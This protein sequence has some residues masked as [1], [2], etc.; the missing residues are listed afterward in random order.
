MNAVYGVDHQNPLKLIDFN[1][2]FDDKINACIK[3]S[4]K[5]KDFI[6]QGNKSY[7]DNKLDEAY[8]MYD[9]CLS[10]YR[11]LAIHHFPNLQLDVI[12]I[13]FAVIAYELKLYKEAIF[14]VN[15]ALLLNS[16]NTAAYFLKSLIYKN[17]S[18]F[19]AAYNTLKTAI[20]ICPHSSLLVRKY[21]QSVELWLQYGVFVIPI[22]STSDFIDRFGLIQNIQERIFLLLCLWNQSSN[23]DKSYICYMLLEVTYKKVFSDGI[24]PQN[25][26]FSKSDIL[27]FINFYDSL[28][29]IGK[30]NLFHSLYRKFLSLN[31]KN[32]VHT[33]LCQIYYNCSQ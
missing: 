25:F 23:E 13:N 31:E 12:L 20:M 6:L 24:C 10:F 28:D 9:S 27:V 5:I 8:E 15:S 3:D 18:N 2:N 19:R 16:S 29:H 33:F 17:R 4:K 1:Y 14:H 7:N 26:P 30:V 32:I 11:G 21:N 22:S